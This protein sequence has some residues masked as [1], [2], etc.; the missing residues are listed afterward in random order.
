MA[1]I[2]ETPLFG[3]YIHHLFTLAKAVQD[4]CDLIFRDTP[5]PETGYYFKIS[6]ELH[7]RIDAVLVAAAN[8]KKLI[9]T[10]TKRGNGEPKKVYELRQNRAKVLAAMLDGLDLE[11]ILNTKVRNSL[12]HF[13]EYLDEVNTNLS[14]GKPVPAPWAGYNM[15]LSHWEATNPRVYPIRIY[16]AAEQKY[17]NMM[18]EIDLGKLRGQ[19]SSI[20]ERLHSLGLL[21]SAPEPGGLMV[22]L[23]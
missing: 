8:I 19:A 5:L 9:Q 12:E 18:Y 17:Y 2:T 11:E 1:K 22:P 14:V 21:H 20:I 16:I 3:V 10:P 13:D 4:N 23:A 6:W 7:A 15:V